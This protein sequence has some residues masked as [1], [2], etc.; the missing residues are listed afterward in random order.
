MKRLLIAF[1]LLCPFLFAQA[2]VSSDVRKS[3]ELST[4][5]TGTI[6]VS[7]TGAVLSYNL[8]KPDKL[9]PVLVDMVVKVAPTWMFV[10]VVRNGKPVAARAKMVLRFTAHKEDNGD[11]TVKLI[12]SHFG[13]NVVE[14]GTEVTR[15]KLDPPA[16]PQS[17][18][19]WNVSGMVYLVLRIDRQGKVA[20]AIAEQVNLTVLGTA[21]ELQRARKVLA[22]ASVNKARQW[23]FVP[24]SKGSQVDDP[25][26]SVRVPVK[27]E[28]D[29][30]A[31]ERYGKW[32]AYVPGPRQEIPWAHDPE[33]DGHSPDTQL[34]GTVNPLG[35]GLKLVTPLSGG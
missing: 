10:P 22:D 18:L 33:A 12:D 3:I 9:P 19:A 34:A 13:E 30:A 15:L 28:L 11:Y 6:E 16:Y 2:G 1:L 7:P 26:W 32:M 25:F 24:P 31:P 27:F 29:G 5:A 21:L 20:D 35:S 4:L 23:T 14:D 17:A 8:D